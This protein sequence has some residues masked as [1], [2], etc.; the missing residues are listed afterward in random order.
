M[1]THDEWHIPPIELDRFVAGVAPKGTGTLELASIEAHL[2][3]CERCRA[4]VA[5]SPLRAA[6]RSDAEATWLRIADRI[7]VS[8]RPIRSSTS[9]LQVCFSSPP[10]IAAT[11]GVAMLLLA[12]VGIVAVVE[13][14]WA[15]HVLLAL[16]PLAPIVGVVLA[17]QTGVDPA[18]DLAAATP[19]ASGRLP[20]L[21]A[22]VAAGASL[23]AGLLATLVVRLPG[24]TLLLWL[25]PG[26]AF[27]A[28]VFAVATW[29]EP[30]RAAAVLATGWMVIIISWVSGRRRGRFDLAL[31]ELVSDQRAVRLLCIGVIVG[32][33]L[34]CH[35]RRDAIPNWRTR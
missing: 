23:L 1:K 29:V 4:G 27:A 8:R 31:D 25:L 10:L 16:A 34:I 35:R 11:L 14:R 13:P 2:L 21:R 3:T 20:L 33:T 19:L 17:F 32:A 22:L 30:S 15:Q 6:R 18:G 28:I 9:P 5:D 24:T 7:D 12:V 26:V